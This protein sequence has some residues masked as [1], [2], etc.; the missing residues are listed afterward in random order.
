MTEET[1]YQITIPVE[2][3]MIVDVAGRKGLKFWEVIGLIDRDDIATSLVDV[4]WDE[5]KDGWRNIDQRTYVEDI[6]N[7]V[8]VCY[9][10]EVLV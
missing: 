2:T 7:D 10:E 1:N 8:E 3:Y 4:E 5:M 6:D 9:E